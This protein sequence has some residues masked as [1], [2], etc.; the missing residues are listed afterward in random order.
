[1]TQIIANIGGLDDMNI[2]RTNRVNKLFKGIAF[3]F[4]TVVLQQC[5]SNERLISEDEDNVIIRNGQGIEFVLIKDG[6][7]YGF[8]ESNGTF[9]VP[10]H[11]VSGLLAGSPENLSPA[12]STKYIGVNNNINS[13]KVVLENNKEI[14]L[15][16]K[17][18]NK[19]ARFELENPDDKPIAMA[20][21]TAGV[22]PGYGLGDVLTNWWQRL[23]ENKG[24]FQTEITGFTNNDYNSSNGYASRMVSNF[25]IY[26]MNQFGLINI[27]S[28]AKIVVSTK[29]EIIQG[30]RHTKKIASFYYFFG[31]PRSIYSGFLTARNENGF[32]VMKPDYEF[33]GVGWEAWGALAWNTSAETVKA[34]IDHYLNLGYPLKWMVIGSGFWP[35]TD[36]KYKSTT[37][38]GMWDKTKYP[39]P[40]EFK[41]YFKEK[42]LK[43]F[44]GLRIA[45]IHNGPF[46]KEG[47]ENGYFL[48]EDGAAKEYKI[49]FPKDLVYLLDVHNEEAVKWYVNLCD[50][51]QV[52]GFKEDVYSYGAYSFPD[53]KIDAVNVALKKKGYQIMI[54]NS[55]LTSPGEL[56]R[57]ED[58][59]YDMNQDR[60]PVNSLTLAYSG[61]PLT[62]MD[63]IGGLF[64]GRDFDGKVSS[65]IKTYLMRNARTAALHSAMSMGKGPWNYNDRQVSEVMLDCALLHARLHPYIYSNAIKFYHDGY[66]HTMTPLPVAYP[67]DINV[68][69]RENYKERGYQWMIGDAL[70]AYPLYGDD[71][72]TAQTR[73][74]YLPEG[75]WIDYDTGKEYYGPLLLNDFE[76][77][78]DKTP[79]FV[80]G[81][82]IVIE[83]IEGELK[84]RIYP[85][86]NKTQTVFYGKDGE[87]QSE[88]S[89]ENP[90]WENLEIFDL[91]ADKK[92]IHEKI[93]H[94]IQFDFIEGHN[95]HIK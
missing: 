54:R 77:S 18:E 93:R 69:G 16:L 59:N 73:N 90:D 57:I 28:G 32:P 47:L 1:M 12:K 67:N 19:Q 15:R 87:T 43:F 42:G 25:A 60:G 81:T 17:L 22:S 63:I 51:W 91:T 79:L 38:F 2:N 58:F 56:H 86:T 3:V 92:V 8:R 46:T 33:Y 4:L 37:S 10:A 50:K 41:Q 95:Y 40:K 9:L 44:I 85:V 52:D 35:Q 36:E 68:H 94:A 7:R 31:N 66:P 78:V 6:F 84:G 55:Y 72:E 39:N 70:L 45:F 53:D 64:G 48:K 11:P 29:D 5:T 76:I 83:E 71:Y 27:D 49:G 82:G 13:F 89:I 61:F 30:S 34:D 88:I 75:K 23:P 62:Y 26:P 24:K 21:R 20:L 14:I 80:G 74:V 65:E